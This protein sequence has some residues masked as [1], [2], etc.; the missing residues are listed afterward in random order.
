MGSFCSAKKK[1]AELIATTVDLK[2]VTDINPKWLSVKALT[3]IKSFMGDEI[4]SLLDLFQQESPEML[5]QLK[6]FNQTHD[7]SEARLIAHTLKSTGA[8]IGA[9]GFSYFCKKTEAAAM[10][11]NQSEVLQNIEKVRKSYVL[12]V[13]EIKK[14]Q[15][16]S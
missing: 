13:N 10:E 4:N 5:D 1:T 14:Y 2:H 12:T 16:G 15:E 9:T 11:G 6:T 7:F 8:N 3:E